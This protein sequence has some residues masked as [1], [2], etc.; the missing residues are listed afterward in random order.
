MATEQAQDENKLSHQLAI[1]GIS[2]QQWNT[3]TKTLYPSAKQS[4]A[5]LALDY[6][7]AR[8]IDP[9]LK[10]IHLVPMWVSDKSLPK[11]G[12]MRDIVLP[13]IYL[14]RIIAMRTGLYNGHSEPQYG[15]EKKFDE[16]MAPEW[17]SMVMFRYSREAKRDIPFPVKCWFAEYVGLTKENKI[18]D[19]WS[20][21]PIQMLTKCCEAAGLR[22]AFPEEFGGETTFEEADAVRGTIEPTV[23]VVEQG[24]GTSRTQ[25]AAATLR[26]RLED[27]S[28]TNELN[29]TLQ[30]IVGQQKE[31]A[32]K[33]RESEWEDK[34]EKMA[35]EVYNAAFKPETKAKNVPSIETA[36]GLIRAATSESKLDEVWTTIVEAYEFAGIEL[37]LEIESVFDIKLEQIQEGGK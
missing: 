8:K 36:N 30:T 1:R 14:Y 4:T 16:I 32:T 12:E 31:M 21:A 2:V 25:A 34:K 33:T 5:L 6:C 19:R 18:N 26:E 35:A 3:L 23:T 37:P 10:A 28:G 24:Q 27:K 20:R 29:K 9:M 13:G 22:E 7:A 11:G 15:P 17:V